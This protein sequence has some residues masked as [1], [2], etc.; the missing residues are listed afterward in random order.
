M[1][2]LI[3]TR[4]SFQLKRFRRPRHD[5]PGYSQVTIRYWYHRR[6]VYYTLYHASAKITLPD[7]QFTG[8]GLR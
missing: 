5:A 1:I 4:H 3:I 7:K 8:L 2:T 6:L